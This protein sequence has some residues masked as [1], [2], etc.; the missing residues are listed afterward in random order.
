[1]C[2]IDVYRERDNE[3]TVE[4]GLKRINRWIGKNRKK[5]KWIKDN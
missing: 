2:E 5:W 3:F 1:M 4:I